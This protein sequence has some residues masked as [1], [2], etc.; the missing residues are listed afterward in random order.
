MGHFRLAYTAFRA[1]LHLSTVAGMAIFATSARAGEAPA[2]ATVRMGTPGWSDIQATNGVVNLLLSG[3]GYKQQLSTLSVPITYQALGNGQTDVFLGDW[4]PAHDHFIEPLL[5]AKKIEVLHRNLDGAKYTLA[6]PDYVAAGGVKTFADLGAHGSEFRHNV[7]G[8]DAGSPGNQ[9]IQKAIDNPT[10]NLQGWTVVPS[11]E[12][13]MLSEVSRDVAHKRWVVF[14]GWAPHPMNTQFNLTYLAGGDAYFGPDFG[15]ATVSTV[16][17]SGFAKACP[18]LARLFTQVTF[19]VPAENVMMNAID[20]DK[21]T[22]TE[23]AAAYLKTHPELLA[24]WIDGV[25]TFDGK[26]G[27]PAVRTSLGIGG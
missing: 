15:A 26:P 5:A 17:R 6:V 21:K 12:Q 10:L 18:N 7:Y 9:S 22:G 4:A 3:L 24:T 20:N 19:S 11:S 25:T 23:A 13:G 8:I 2:C 14:L 16:A 27:L 1:T